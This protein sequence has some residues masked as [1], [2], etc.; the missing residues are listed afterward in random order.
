MRL[1]QAAAILMLDALST[2]AAHARDVDAD[3]ELRSS[4]AAAQIEGQVICL[5]A[6]N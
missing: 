3:L 1:P 5:A 2:M 6:S 4:L